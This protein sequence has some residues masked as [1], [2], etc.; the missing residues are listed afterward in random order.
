MLVR[1][2]VSAWAD[3]LQPEFDKLG[4]TLA[5]PTN[6]DSIL[7]DRGVRIALALGQL[8]RRKGDDSLAWRALL[9][10][11]PGIGD[12]VV[13]HIYS[14][15]GSGNFAARL[16]ALHANGFAE[17][18]NRIE[19]D[20]M[21]QSIQDAMVKVPKRK[22]PPNGESWAGWLV[23]QVKQMDPDAFTTIAEDRFK[24]IGDKAG[25]R[26]LDDLLNKFQAT[27]RQS[28]SGPDNQIL[29][30]TMAMSKG[31][32]FDTAIMMGAEEGNIPAPQGDPA[33]E[34]RYLYVALTRATY[35]TVVTYA[36]ERTTGPTAPI[37]QSYGRPRESRHRS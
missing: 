11:T 16:L 37:G 3:E 28:A 22:G 6:V 5:A 35:L 29:I 15:A 33:E 12:S 17:L 8:I 4:V 18:R 31:L 25:Q 36:E 13:D 27:L 21:V 19:V 2:D 34:R 20:A 23:E 10:V 14:G 1:S 7:Q 30:M 24:T 9:K 26:D 32:T